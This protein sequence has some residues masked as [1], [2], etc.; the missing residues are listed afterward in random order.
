MSAFFVAME[1]SFK[2]VS[3]A[4]F[5]SLRT[6]EHLTVQCAGEQSRFTRFNNSRVRQ[7]GTVQDGV[8]KLSLLSRSRYL[9]AVVPFCADAA[10]S[11]ARAKSLLAQM[12]TTADALPVDPFAIVPQNTGSTLEQHE[13]D[14]PPVDVHV[15]DMMTTLKP[16]DAAGYFAGGPAFRGLA[17]SAGQYH[18]F[19]TTNFFLDYSL[20]TPAEKSVKLCYAGQRWKSEEFVAQVEHAKEMLTHL[21]K[22]PRKIERGKYR[23]YLAPAATSSLLD[24]FSWNGISEGA[25]RRAESCVLQMRESGKKLS[26]QFTLREN[27]TMG[28]TPRFNEFGE[29]S[30]EILPLIENG[31]LRTTLT[32]SRSAKQYGVTSNAASSSE[33][34][35]AMEMLPGSLQQQ[36]VLKALGTGLYLSNLHYLNWSDVVGG[37]ITGMTR[38]ACFWVEDGKI[39]AP[40]QDL[41][42]DESL[43]N[44]LGDGLEAVTS[45][46]EF[47]PATDTYG[48]RSLGGSRNPG[49]L[50]KDF[51]FT[52]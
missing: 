45:F 13:G 10:S 50:V 19:G 31:E 26:Q 41:R 52:L 15:K 4:L 47:S 2:S 16:F 44:F 46:A 34:L 35:R 21:Q 17:N 8:L 20:Y 49:I 5:K 32:S 39:V 1:P 11:I 25:V 22:T 43:Y 23:T 7:S 28:S 29:V 33:F 12:Q 14:I 42:F 40:I 30:A 24:M 37:R 27:F 36:D 51:T 18:W 9:T 6:D 48:V 3:E 38:Y